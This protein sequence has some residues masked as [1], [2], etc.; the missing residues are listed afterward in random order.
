[1]EI[2]IVG[3][4]VSDGLGRDGHSLICMVLMVIRSD[5]MRG[6]AYEIRGA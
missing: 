3:A 4:D 5:V 2:G 1:M 6:Q